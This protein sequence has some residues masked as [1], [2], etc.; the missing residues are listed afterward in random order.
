MKI[1][2]NMEQLGAALDAGDKLLF[3]F[4]ETQWV[5]LCTSDP[6][7]TID[8][9]MEAIS[10]NRLRIAQ[11]TTWIEGPGGR[12][13][14]PEPESVAAE[15]GDDYWIADITAKGGVDSYTWGD[16]RVD[17]RCFKTKVIH[18]T[19]ENAKAHANAMIKAMGGSVDE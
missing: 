6:S 15:L 9:L 8:G 16:G 1:I 14:Y 2:K 19:E 11:R 5:P 12:F 13:E 4:S 10:S 3:E 7:W 18:L 17:K